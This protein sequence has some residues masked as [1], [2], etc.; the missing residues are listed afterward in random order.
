LSTNV[1]SDDRGQRIIRTKEDGSISSPSEDSDD[2]RPD[3][4]NNSKCYENAIVCDEAR[5]DE[6]NRWSLAKL[7]FGAEY[8]PS[9]H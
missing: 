6:I 9:I 5:T 7:E 2:Q 1:N 8:F 4:Q 3:G